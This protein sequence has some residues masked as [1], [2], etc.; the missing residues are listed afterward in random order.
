MMKIDKL[1]IY[2]GDPYPVTDKITIYQPSIQDIIDYGEDDWWSTVNVFIGNTTSR[3]FVLWK[4]GADWNKVSDYELFCTLAPT[5][6]LEKTKCFFGDIDFQKF[7]P[8]SIQTNKPEEPEEEPLDENG[9]PRKLTAKEKR[10]KRFR[11]FDDHVTLYNVEQ[12]IEIDVNTYKTIANVM[13]EI[14]H[15]YPKT[16]YAVGK[17]TKELIM[18]EEQNKLARAKDEDNGSVLQPLISMC[19]NHPGFKYKL[20]ELREINVSQFMDSVSRL[21]ILETTHALLNGAYSGFCDT[22]KIPKEQFDFTRSI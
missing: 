19:V 8:M 12:D 2:F 3:R 5:L 10:E 13:R 6:P 15:I 4:M 14:V 18:E 17:A 21:Q 20:Q 16:E 7:V 22:S 1:K 9:K 11:A